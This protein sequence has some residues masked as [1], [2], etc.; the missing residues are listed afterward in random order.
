[1]FKLDCQQKAL[2]LILAVCEGRLK[3]LCKGPFT[4]TL[5]CTGEGER[6]FV[7]LK[8][9]SLLSELVVPLKHNVPL[10]LG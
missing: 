1:M 3:R 2:C 8:C 5:R 6:V 9:I 10:V 7:Q 4:H